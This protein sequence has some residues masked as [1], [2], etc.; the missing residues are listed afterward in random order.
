MSH[1]GN[2]E[3]LNLL[4]KRK[5]L[6][7]EFNRNILDM[8]KAIDRQD[9]EEDIRKIHDEQNRILDEIHQQNS[10]INKQFD[11]F[12]SFL[13]DSGSPE[14][15]LIEEIKK[16][17]QK[18]WRLHERLVEKAEEERNKI[19]QEIAKLKNDK[20]ELARGKKIVTALRAVIEKDNRLAIKT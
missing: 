2:G 16:L 8:L 6:R 3:I 20:A 5:E 17:T 12:N 19:K 7:Q 10:S 9:I 1:N 11:R 18:S 4:E 15:R 14:Y 13:N